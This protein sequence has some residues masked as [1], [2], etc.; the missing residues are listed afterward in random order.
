MKWRTA[1]PWLLRGETAFALA[2]VLAI[3][4]AATTLIFHRL[5]LNNFGLPDDAGY[6]DAHR[7]IMTIYL[8][9]YVTCVTPLVSSALFGIESLWRRHLIFWSRLSYG[10]LSGALLFWCEWSLQT[11]LDNGHRFYRFGAPVDS[12]QAAAYAAV[13]FPFAIACVCVLLAMMRR[14]PKR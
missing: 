13:L 2:V 9:P 1:S 8:L 14:A 3:F 11:D 12:V 5:L 10:A 7:D 6:F 4:W